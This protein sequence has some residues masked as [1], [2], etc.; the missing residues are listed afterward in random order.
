MSTK[1]IW[2]GL[3]AV[4][5]LA[6]CAAVPPPTQA[7]LTYETKPLGAELFEGSQ[8]LGMG[9]VTRTYKGDPKVGT[10]E[11]PDVKAV[12]PSGAST[13]FFTIL[14]LGSDRQATLERPA[15][16]PGLQQDLDNAKKV[17][18]ARKQEAA[19]NKALDQGELARNSARCQA[20]M[21]MGSKGVTDDCR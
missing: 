16:A 7:T 10:V 20:Q 5:G 1:S 8:S 14:P 3:A 6:G 9:P 4:L 15:T 21:A 12:W 11:T 17:E 13:T 18:I 19:R 2:L